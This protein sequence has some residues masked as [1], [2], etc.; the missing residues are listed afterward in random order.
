[1]QVVLATAHAKAATKEILSMHCISIV[2]L[3]HP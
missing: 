1:M 2:W 3:H